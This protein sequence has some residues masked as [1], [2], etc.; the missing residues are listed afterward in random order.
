MR[1]GIDFCIKA[2]RSLVFLCPLRSWTRAIRWLQRLAS[3]T[4]Y[5]LASLLDMDVVA[6]A[7]AKCPRVVWF[8]LPVLCVCW[9][10]KCTW[11]PAW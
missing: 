8:R 2:N 6:V 9:M 1:Y 11:M 10:C 3:R 4:V 7:N 5:L